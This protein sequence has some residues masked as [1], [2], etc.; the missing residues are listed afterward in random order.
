MPPLLITTASEAGNNL[1]EESFNLLSSDDDNNVHKTTRADHEG[2]LVKY[3]YF[4]T[5]EILFFNSNTHYSTIIS[6]KRGH[7]GYSGFYNNFTNLF[8][9]HHHHHLDS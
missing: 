3:K 1:F 2:C 7:R 8:F 5:A 6:L 9:L 4:I